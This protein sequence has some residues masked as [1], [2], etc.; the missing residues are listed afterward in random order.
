MRLP[1]WLD[2]HELRHLE[3]GERVARVDDHSDA[4]WARLRIAERLRRRA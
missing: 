4:V 1:I 3:L 2:D